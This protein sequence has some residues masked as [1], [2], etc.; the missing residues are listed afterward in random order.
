MSLAS[1]SGQSNMSNDPI[2]GSSI[3]RLKQI[4]ADRSQFS[5]AQID[6]A[7]YKLKSIL[8]SKEGMEAWTPKLGRQIG[9]LIRRVDGKAFKELQA[10]VSGALKD[11]VLHASQMFNHFDKEFADLIKSFK[12]DKTDEN[13]KRAGKWLT[14]NFKWFKGINSEGV[15]LTTNQQNIINKKLEVLTR[16]LPKE[17]ENPDN[18]GNL[19]RLIQSLLPKRIP[20]DK[21]ILST[22]IND[23]R[24]VEDADGDIHTVH[25]KGYL[26][27]DSIGAVREI[28]RGNPSQG[29]RLMAQWIELNQIPLRELD[30]TN[31]EFLGIAPLLKYV[32]LK[33]YQFPISTDESIR[34][35]KK[36]EGIQQLTDEEIRQFKDE[37]IQQFI[38]RFKKAEIL[39]IECN[40]I[41]STIPLLPNLTD[42]NCS[43][44]RH[45]TVLPNN[46]NN[47]QELTCIDCKL[48]TAIP[49]GLTSLNWLQCHNCIA[50]DSLPND[51]NNLIALSCSYCSNLRTLPEN[52]N[53]CKIISCVNCTHLSSIPS[54]LNSLEILWCS[55]CPELRTLPKDLKS[56]KELKCDEC[57]NLVIPDEYTHLIAG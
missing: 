53:N 29:F 39:N 44:C 47:L 11:E 14:N 17:P 4:T 52:L 38:S 34:Q 35:L 9:A 25:N 26:G 30:L 50:L 51:L 15:P 23:A 16:A 36:D 18:I 13:V 10:V 57:P 12:K 28:L 37:F 20:I 45:L 22:L 48:L 3:N 24:L 2:Y 7:I 46:L 56:L 41:I 49:I 43:E 33:E 5:E 1:P 6:G 42:L 55:K 27:K 32:D 54:K 40:E 31:E 21:Y 8:Y 19:R